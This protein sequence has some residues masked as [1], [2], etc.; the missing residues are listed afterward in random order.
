M[1]LAIEIRQIAERGDLWKLTVEDVINLIDDIY[2]RLGA[3]IELLRPKVFDDKECGR[4]WERSLQKFD[5]LLLKKYQ[6][7]YIKSEIL[8]KMGGIE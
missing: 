5:E 1:L 3:E 7:K 4:S 8:N 2:D 6:T